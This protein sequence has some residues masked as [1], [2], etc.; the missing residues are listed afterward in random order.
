MLAALEE[1]EVVALRDMYPENIDDVALFQQLKGSGYVF[2]TCDSSQ[3]T[4]ARE[5]AALKEAGLTALF[6]GPFWSKK[7]FMDQAKW[8]I[9]RWELI[10]RF[11][12][13]VVPGVCAELTERGKA[14]PFRLT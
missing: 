8:I 14:N 2:I 3:T 4:R 11:A 1:W 7:S 9:S 5:A 10:D 13:A 6:L 12:S